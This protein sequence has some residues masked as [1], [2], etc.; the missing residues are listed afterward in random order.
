MKLRFASWNVNNRNLTPHHVKILRELRPDI[1][2]L[3]E[4]SPSLHEALATEDLFAWAAFSLTLRPPRD[5]EGRSRRL[6]CSV[7]GTQRFPLLTY[8]L[9]PRLPF[10]ERTLVAAVGARGAGLTVCS[11]HTP[12]GASW[13]EV[14]PRTLKAIARWLPLSPHPSSSESTRI[15]Q[16]PTTR[17]SLETSGGGRMRRFFLAPRRSMSSR[18]SFEPTSKRTRRNSHVPSLRGRTDRSRF[19][20]FAVTVAL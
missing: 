5:D 12:P 2:A 13:G 6:G 1:A 3:Q 16:R 4:V 10:R 9:V 8:S 15:A 14:K 20:T 17:I 7:F 19:H 11:F 18:M